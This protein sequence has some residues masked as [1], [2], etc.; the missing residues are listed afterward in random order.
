MSAN[1][2]DRTDAG[3]Q[4]AAELATLDL[5]PPRI[6]LVPLHRGYDGLSEVVTG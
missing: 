5:P 6:V 3:R 2:R 1:F 4:L